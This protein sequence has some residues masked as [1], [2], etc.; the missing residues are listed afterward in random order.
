MPGRVPLS[1]HFCGVC[2][3]WNGVPGRQEAVMSVCR[4]STLVA[5]AWIG[6]QL[7]KRSYDSIK[8]IKSCLSYR[9]DFCGAIITPKRWIHGTAL[10]ALLL[11]PHPE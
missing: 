10:N 1:L 9:N 7:M 2:G 5:N 11:T 3:V 6:Y 4:A 8:P